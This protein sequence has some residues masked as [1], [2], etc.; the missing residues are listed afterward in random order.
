M[1]SGL[2]DL[3]E[4]EVTPEEKLAKEKAEEELKEKNMI[5]IKTRLDT[6]HLY[7]GQP[8]KTRQEAVMMSVIM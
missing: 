7:T 4:P 1:S 5:T 2:R 6:V 3:A 8:S